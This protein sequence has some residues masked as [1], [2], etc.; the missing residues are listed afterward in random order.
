MSIDSDDIH[1]QDELPGDAFEKDAE[2]Q[3]D[4]MPP[5]DVPESDPRSTTGSSQYKFVEDFRSNSTQ[6]NEGLS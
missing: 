4:K 6:F 1:M 2:V 5:V 3:F